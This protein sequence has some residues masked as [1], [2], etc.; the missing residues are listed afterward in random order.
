MDLSINGLQY[1][2]SI[3]LCSY[4]ELNITYLMWI[5]VSL[6]KI[7]PRTYISLLLSCIFTAVTNSSSIYIYLVKMCT[8]LLILIAPFSFNRPQYSSTLEHPIPPVLGCLDETLTQPPPPFLEKLALLAHPLC[9]KNIE[10]LY[11]PYLLLSEAH[12][13]LTPSNVTS[14]L[15]TLPH[16]RLTT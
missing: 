16:H 12:N 9:R 15:T 10:N 7:G 11:S 1:L 8:I 6:T 13:H 5:L 2:Y 4:T 14:K 3:P